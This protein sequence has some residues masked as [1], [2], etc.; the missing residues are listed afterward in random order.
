M[1]QQYATVY[2]EGKNT[3]YCSNVLQQMENV[4]S[5]EFI[6]ERVEKKQLRIHGLWF[7]IAKA[8]VYYYEKSLNQFV[9][10]DEEEAKQILKRMTL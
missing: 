5:Y 7:D 4:A 3:T 10:I 2:E 6:M 8:N 1:R 9:L